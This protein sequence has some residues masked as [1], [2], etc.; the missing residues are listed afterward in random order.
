[1]WEELAGQ[2]VHRDRLTANRA[3]L[4]T[5]Y[6]VPYRSEDQTMSPERYAHCQ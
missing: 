2:V 1:M 6:T 3:Y 4:K 5:L